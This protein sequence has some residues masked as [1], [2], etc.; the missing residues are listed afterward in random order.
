[1]ASWS[2]YLQGF[3]YIALL[4]FVI[5]IRIKG[6]DQAEDQFQEYLKK[7]NKTYDD[8][9]VYQNRF[10]AFKKSLETIETLN[11]KKRNGSAMYGL[12]KFSDLLPEEFFETYLQSNLSQKTHSNQPKR[13]RHKRASV[14]NKV[15]WRE[16]NAVTKIYNQGNCGACWAYSVI[17]TVESMNAI[18][19]NKSEELSVQEI[20]DCAGNNKG[21][22]GG[23]ICTL[24]SWIKNT[25]FTIQ[26]HADYSGKCR[27]GS[28][29]VQIRDFMCE[30]LVGSEDVMLKLLADN[31]PLAVA[32]NAQT[33][34]NY[35]GGVIEYHC[36]GDPSKLNH[37]VQI[38]GY[39]LTAN[40][41]HYI[42]RNTWGEDFGDRGFLY[43]AVN[44]NMC[45]IANEVSAL[46]IL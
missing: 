37:A 21:C 38:V 24:L 4:F 42:V 20:I 27:R 39:D 2:T 8:P 43:V 33:W 30:G 25:N 12:T 26:R 35:I 11:T 46:R 15:D 40:I 28:T 3:F 16:K 29:G 23:D 10:Q 22:N 31:G 6:P 14:P 36:D 9:I 17:E 1:M 13:H 18:K 45:G 32:I 7:F 5:P 19:T 44:K 41:P 34:Q